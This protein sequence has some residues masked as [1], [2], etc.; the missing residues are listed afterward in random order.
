[1]L[2]QAVWRAAR[3]R[4]IAEA[5]PSAAAAVRLAVAQGFVVT[6]GQALDAGVSEA[7]VRRFVRRGI[8]VRASYGV[9]SV[10]GAAPWAADQLDEREV[11]RRAHVVRCAAA[12]LV[13]SDHVVC[14]RSAAILLGL[15]C[16]RTPVSP[17]MVVRQP[18]TLGEYRGVLVRGARLQP[19]DEMT[20][21]GV[22]VTTVERTVVD[23]ARL[24]RSDGIMAGDCAARGELL[25][26]RQ[27]RG[28]LAR[29][30]GWPGVRSARL[31]A[32][33]LNPLAESPF[34]SVVRLALHEAG[35]P[36]P[37]LQAEITDPVS[38]QHYRVDFVW[39]HRRLVLEADGR[40]K[41]T[42]DALWEEKQRELGLARAG[43]RVE[44]VIWTDLSRVR[45]AVVVARLRQLL[46]LPPPT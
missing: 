1:V 34:E 4:V 31:V 12:A 28:A 5:P 18:R 39:R 25:D 21:F 29:C 15:P 3:S 20:W 30:V 41:Y 27:L 7:E 10:L 37:E 24:D 8:W 19:I 42:D 44:R 26:S 9:L 6:R 22:P 33:L 17:V 35:L 45:W 23:L 14:G 38:G 46:A 43:Y 36:A 32:E 40:E 13:R 11:E 16:M 2:W